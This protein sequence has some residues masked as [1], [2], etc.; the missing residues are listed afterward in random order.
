[1]S[2]QS[3]PRTASDV[4]AIFLVALTTA[5]ADLARVVQAILTHDQLDDEVRAELKR[6]VANSMK[7][8]GNELARIRPELT[9]QVMKR[10]L[11]PIDGETHG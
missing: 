11:R 8:F 3:E 6:E 7:G 2:D 1:M 9:D 4:T 5:H 10:Y